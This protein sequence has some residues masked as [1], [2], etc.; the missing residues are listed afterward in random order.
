MMDA[1][2]SLYFSV[3]RRASEKTK[4]ED[5]GNH[6]ALLVLLL[7]GRNGVLTEQIDLGSKTFKMNV[8]LSLCQ[9][10]GTMLASTS[11][12]ERIRP[13]QEGREQ[14]TQHAGL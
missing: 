9:M 7:C 2:H 6:D 4:K 12:D 1:I 11:T 10:L 3:Y 14:E 13:T 5:D 8:I